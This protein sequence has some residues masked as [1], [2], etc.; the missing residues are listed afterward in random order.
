VRP[1][2]GVVAALA[3]VVLLPAC[4]IPEESEPRA[5]APDRIPE[6]LQPGDT[7]PPITTEP[8]GVRYPIYML[9]TTA[10]GES[11]VLFPYEV[12]FQGPDTPS[13]RSMVTRLLQAGPAESE[14]LPAGVF[15]ALPDALSFAEGTEGFEIV[16]DDLARISLNDAIENV[17]N[18]RFTQAIAQIVF[19]ATEVGDVNRV[20]FVD[21]EGDPIEIPLEESSDDVVTRADFAELQPE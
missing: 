17:E 4:G 5:V 3:V 7:A 12:A 6:Q 1:V 13:P 18:E 11:E 10:D 8:T 15:N 16:D 19:T 21:D 2:A 20:Q 14:T 9:T